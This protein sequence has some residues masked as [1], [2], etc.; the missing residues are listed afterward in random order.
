[1]HTYAFGT[2]PELNPFFKIVTVSFPIPI[3]DN[4]FK[5]NSKSTWVKLRKNKNINPVA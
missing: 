2:L 5:G 3:T 1:M 4:M